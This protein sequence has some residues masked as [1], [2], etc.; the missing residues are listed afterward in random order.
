VPLGFG[1]VYVE[2]PGKLDGEA[3]LAGLNAGRS[4]V[5]T[6][7][8]LLATVNG[9]PAGQKIS[10]GPDA[11]RNYRVQVECHSPHPFDSVEII[12]NGEVARGIDV[13]TRRTDP[14][15]NAFNIDATIEISGSSWIA[16]RVFTTLPNGRV[17]FAHSSPVHIDIRGRPLRPRKVEV[18]Y[19]AGR[20]RKQI[21]RSTGTLPP[22]AIAE[23]RKALA[24]YERLLP[25]AR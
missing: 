17:R 14:G 7:P 4:F 6:G 3:W 5:T 10:V 23:Y 9:K 19:L 22:A 18:E 15:A 2:I 13:Q 12:V 8:M 24:A 11:S 25:T 16:V 1:R 20:V 21:E